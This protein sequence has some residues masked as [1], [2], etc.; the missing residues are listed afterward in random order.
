VPQGWELGGDAELTAGTIDPENDGWLRLTSAV[1]DELGYAIS[2]DPV[3]TSTG[4]L[5]AFDFVS[6]GGNGADGFS[7]FLWDQKW[8]QNFG[9]NTKE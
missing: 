2:T 5:V 8:S 1:N 7:V 4:L 3:D 6:W 9:P